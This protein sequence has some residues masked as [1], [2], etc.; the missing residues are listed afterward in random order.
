MQEFGQYGWGGWQRDH[1]QTSSEMPTIEVRNVSEML[2]SA[3][4]EAHEDVIIESTQGFGL[5]S[6]HSKHYPFATSRDVTP[7]IILNDAGLSSRENHRVYAVVRTMPIR[8]AGNSGDLYKETDWDTLQDEIPHLERPELTTVTG[9]PR[10]IGK[11]LDLEML[12]SM[13]RHCR[14]DGICLTFMDYVFPE[15][16]QQRNLYTLSL[17]HI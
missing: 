16:H 4:H 3:I 11:E 15:T 13:V 1:W 12:R 7:G 9:N 14:P 6:V 8:V 17:I 5:S 10:R 2:E